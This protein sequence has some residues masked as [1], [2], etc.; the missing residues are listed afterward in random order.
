MADNQANAASANDPA[1]ASDSP[2]PNGPGLDTGPFIAADEDLA[3]DAASDMATS[4][5]SSSSTLIRR[6]RIE[7]GRTY[8]HK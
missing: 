2:P 7:N 5:A 4:V 8:H 3:D 1:P 6:H